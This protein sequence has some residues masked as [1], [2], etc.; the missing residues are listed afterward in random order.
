[1]VCYKMAEVVRRAFTEKFRLEILSSSIYYLVAI[2]KV[3]VIYSI[4]G[5]LSAKKCN[6]WIKY[7]VYWAR[8]AQLYGIY[9]ILY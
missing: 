7:G 3:V 8:S 5:R 4:F 6:F 9:C 1:M 2:L